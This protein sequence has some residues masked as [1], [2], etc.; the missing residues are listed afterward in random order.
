MAF[1]TLGGDEMH[2]TPRENSPGEQVG[3]EEEKDSYSL[4]YVFPQSF[5][6]YKANHHEM[7]FILSAK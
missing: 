4:R 1:L 6:R 3:W 5:A 7:K 2:Q